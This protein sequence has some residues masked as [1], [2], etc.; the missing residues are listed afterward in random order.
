M[1]LFKNLITLRKDLTLI[2]FISILTIILMDFW[3]NNIPEIFNGASKIGQ[4][5]YNICFAYVSAFIF[6][7][8]VV[9]IKIQK[10]KD[11]LYGYISI[12]VAHVIGQAN[13]VV[14]ELS[15][16]SNITL[17]SKYPTEEELNLILKSIV[18]ASNAPLLLG[19]NGPYANWIQYLNYWRDR[20]NRFSNNVLSK[21]QFL[22]SELISI[23]TEIEDCS[24]FNTLS[25]FIHINFINY[26]LK[27]FDKIFYEYL[28]K[29]KELENYYDEYLENY[30]NK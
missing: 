1:K 8:L 2:F 28:N 27:I 12:N 6:Y 15:K 10:D 22:D 14:L 3:L 25:N 29:I 23:L 7:F 20:S 30:R 5:I 19:Y 26:D 4:I 18:A 17:K 24:Y 9:H 13:A 16:S 21:M 11:N